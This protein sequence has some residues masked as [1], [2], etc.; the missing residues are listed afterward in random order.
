MIAI[1]SLALLPGLV[2]ISIQVW[3]AYNS[4]KNIKAH[5]EKKR[6]RIE[7]EQKMLQLVSYM[8]YNNSMQAYAN[9]PDDH[10]KRYTTFTL[11]TDGTL[12]ADANVWGGRM[13]LIAS[14]VHKC[15]DGKTGEDCSGPPV[16]NFCGSN[17]MGMITGAGHYME[18]CMPYN[19]NGNSVNTGMMGN[20]SDGVEMSISDLVDDIGNYPD[21]YYMNFHSI[22][23][24]SYWQSHGGGVMI[25]DTF[26]R[27]THLNIEKVVRH[28]LFY[29]YFI[30]ALIRPAVEH[31]I[32]RISNTA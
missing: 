7:R 18:E 19:S 20:V 8:K 25:H 16:I 5:L 10:A 3:H 28:K 13:D 30:R 15:N 2:G 21:N 26:R 17:D 31:V 32:R 4:G 9:S 12:T 22:A 14:H 6:E 23:S 29:F 27:Y 1:A 24:W 11:C